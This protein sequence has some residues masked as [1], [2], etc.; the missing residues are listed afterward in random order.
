VKIP[1]HM[2]FD[3]CFAFR[4]KWS[5]TALTCLLILA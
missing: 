3:L 2:Y 1:L 4:T 5:S